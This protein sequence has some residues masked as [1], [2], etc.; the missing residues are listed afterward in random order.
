MPKR[1]SDT[2]AGAAFLREL[3]HLRHQSAGRDRNIPLA[4]M[5]SAFIGQKT[6]KTEQIV[7]IVKRL[8]AS[9]DH[10]IRNAFADIQTDPVDLIQ[11]FRGTQV[12]DQAVQGG[13]AYS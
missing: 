7:I 2:A 8:P 12:P 3:P 4:D 5:K 1:N 13:R 6:D 10:N 9:H 11:H